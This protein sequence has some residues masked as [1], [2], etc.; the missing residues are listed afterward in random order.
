MAALAAAE[1]IER[2]G[3]PSVAVKWPN[4]LLINERKIGGILCESGTAA[5]SGPFQVIGIG[6]NV[7]G[8]PED[9]PEELRGTATTIRR[10]TG[11][12]I[13]RNRLLAQLL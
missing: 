10:E 8:E 9:F 12:F 7:N 13:D 4:D 2:R 1:G 6:I 3:Q 11:S 5:P